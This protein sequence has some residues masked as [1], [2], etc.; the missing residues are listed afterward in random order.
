MITIQ[1]PSMYRHLAGNRATVS[2]T[3]ST[4]REAHAEL[5]RICPALAPALADPAGELKA[6]VNIFVE[7]THMRDL[8]GWETPLAP[9]S[10]I[11]LL[12]AMA[13]G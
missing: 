5:L 9:G 8:Q 7:E 4:V 11:V 2:V 13:G 3:A 10:R 1:L 12:M 6:A